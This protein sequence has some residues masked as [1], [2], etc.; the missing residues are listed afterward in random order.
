MKEMQQCQLPEMQYTLM[1]VIAE[2]YEDIGDGSRALLWRAKA[3]ETAQNVDDDDIKYEAEC[4]LGLALADDATYALDDPH[5]VKQAEWKRAKVKDLEI[6]FHESERRSDWLR[7]FQ[8]ARKL[9]QKEL[10]EDIVSKRPPLGTSWLPQVQKSL[11]HLNDDK[12]RN[13]EAWVAFTMAHAKFEAG[14]FVESISILAQVAKKG[15]EMGNKDIASRAFFTASRAHMEL[16]KISKDIQD[17]TGFDRA[18]MTCQTMSEEQDRPDMVAC[19]HVLRAMAWYERKH[20]DT[21][22]LTKALEYITQAQRVWSTERLG[23]ISDSTLSTLLTHYS[24]TGR[25]A[26]TPHPVHGLA[27][28]ICFELRRFKEAFQWAECGK[29][30]AFRDSLETNDLDESPNT[31]LEPVGIDMMFPALEDPVLLVHWVFNGDAIYMCTCRIGCDYNVFK[32]DITAA[33]VEEWNQNLVSTNDN[34]SDADSALE[35]LSELKPLC[36]PLLDAEVTSPGDILLLCPTKVLFKIPLHAIP[37]EDGEIL[38]DHHPIVYT[39]AFSIL[40]ECISRRRRQSYNL[41]K[42]TIVIGN[43]TGDTPAGQSSAQQIAT[44]LSTEPLIQQQATKEKFLLYAPQSQLI[45][46]HGHAQLDAYP[47]DQCMLFHHHVPLKVREIFDL[48]LK[49]SYPLVV[50]ISCGSGIERLD[51]GDEPLGL[52]SSYLHA[53]ASAVVAT[54][55]AIHDRLAGATF[56]EMFYG[57][58]D[59]QASDWT[60]GKTINVARRLQ[61]AALS[62]KANEATRAPYFWAAF[63]LHGDWNTRLN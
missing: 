38:L 35:M 12:R 23:V 47:L 50:L 6:L 3:N 41:Q 59:Q 58:D 13:E 31:L 30:Q 37:L 53:G 17:W 44:L 14:E 24:M 15:L 40:S 36:Q 29:A 60:M 56:S 18:L 7:C 32:L 22:A 34:L 20:E 54:M 48:D 39:H 63:V 61:R 8:Y 21:D 28:E 51:D 1:T 52:V 57:L 62:I 27:V 42:R 16:F 43:A 26:R 49:S 55:W 25:N 9:L 33:I 5:G 19:C 2:Y 45:H 11:H 4:A 46:V 10:D